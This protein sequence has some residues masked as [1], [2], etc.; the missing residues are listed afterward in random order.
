MR[1]ITNY[2]KAKKATHKIESA[3][4]FMLK[5]LLLFIWKS[6]FDGQHKDFLL[7]NICWKYLVYSSVF[8]FLRNKPK[9]TRKSHQKLMPFWRLFRLNYEDEGAI[10]ISFM[11]GHLFMSL[12]SYLANSAS[13]HNRVTVTLHIGQL[14][15]QR[16]D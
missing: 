9:N 3:S 1:L 16:R 7:Q 11:L 8:R 6:L 15:H 5:M 14:A 2:K 10:E 12:M 4:Y 13:Y